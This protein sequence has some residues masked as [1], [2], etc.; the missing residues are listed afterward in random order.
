MALY[1]PMDKYT[2]GPGPDA[3]QASLVTEPSASGHLLLISPDGAP[4]GKLEEQLRRLGFEVTLLREAPEV[5]AVVQ[6][7][8]LALDA[9]VLDWRSGGE[10]DQTFAE[11]LAEAAANAQIPVLT[12]AADCRTDDI[13]LA[14][15]AG[16]EQHLCMPCQL[17][18]LKAALMAMIVRPAP[19][20]ERPSAAINL[21]DAVDLLENCKF[22]FRTPE[23]VEK[24]VPLLARLFPHPG[25]AV[26]GI[27]ELMMNAI[28][29]GNLEIGHELKAYWIARGIY[30][31]ELAKRLATPPF[32]AR[33]AEVIINKREDG[34][35]I[36]IMDQGCGFCWQN[37]VRG[38][39][40]PAEAVVDPSGHGIAIARDVSFDHLRFNHQGNQ[41]TA[42]VSNESPAW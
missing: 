6:A 18:Q 41:V 17:S 19:V 8:V 15:E 12:L 20:A 13:R 42:F 34:V 33:W 4:H 2:T 37:L 26:T 30:Q 31:S 38:E 3:G 23:D 28:E 40:A 36:V 1:Q 14:A 35:M 27:A 11:A 25:R 7:P 16:L 22:R 32:S 39:P 5:L 21:G 29:H 9:I 10:K 24:L